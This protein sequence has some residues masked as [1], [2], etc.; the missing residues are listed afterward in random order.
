MPFN[1][2]TLLSV[3]GKSIAVESRLMTKRTTDL[4]GLAF[5]V[6]LTFGVA[7]L[8]SQFQPGEWFQSL[9]KPAWNP[10]GWLFGESCI[11]R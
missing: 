9:A 8:S 2:F 5:W 11:S 6:L 3:D 4:I 7:T 1:Y 10:P